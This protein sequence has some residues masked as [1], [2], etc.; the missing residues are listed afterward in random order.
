MI[1]SRYITRELYLNTIAITLIVLL[2]FITNQFTHFLKIAAKGGITLTT[3]LQISALQVPLL[4][5]YLLPLG[6]YL[7]IL[8]VFGRFYTDHEM[9]VMSAC[10]ISHT[11][12]LRIVM[13]AAVPIFIAVSV[14]MFWIEPLAERAQIEVLNNSLQNITVDKIMPHRFQTLPNDSV[15]YA[16]ARNSAATKLYQAFFIK[17]NSNGSLEVVTASTVNQQS[18]PNNKGGKFLVFHKGYHYTGTVGTTNFRLVKFNSLGINRIASKR[19]YSNWSLSSSTLE[20]WKMRHKK[21]AAAILQWRL[22]LPL[23][24][25]I[26]VMLGFPLSRINPRNGKFAKFIPAILIYVG[27]ADLMYLGRVWITKGTLSPNLGMWWIHGVVLL[28]AIIFNLYPWLKRRKFY[29]L[30]RGIYAHT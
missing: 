1:L 23:S 26:L 11:K 19:Q 5:G 4:L 17:P 25:F 14:L 12:I 27:Y 28:L 15:F 3:V 2:I 20:L 9:T 8:L 10:G 24:V 29:R 21:A 7:A 6:L 22:A 18:N 16:K 30:R 13:L